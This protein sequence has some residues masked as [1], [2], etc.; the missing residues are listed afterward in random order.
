V[1]VTDLA[2][3]EVGK[4]DE[5]GVIWI[6]ADA[7]GWGW[8]VDGTPG[9]DDEFA[10]G[11]DGVLLAVSDPAAGR[12]DLLSVLAHEL[13]HAA[14]LGHQEHGL[15]TPTIV[16]GQRL[17][18]AV[19]GATTSAGATATAGATANVSSVTTANVSPLT[20]PDVSLVTTPEL[21]PAANPIV[22]DWSAAPAP[23][24]TPAAAN[25][26]WMADFANHLGRTQAEREPTAKLRIAAAPQAAAKLAGEAVRRISSLFG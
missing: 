9:T 4:T 8:F 19:T 20:A 3:L 14:G 11:A 23:V 25:P 6:D 15:M 10:M 22:I 24:A 12:M 1:R 18:P 26:G 21:P 17:A 13:A 16:A 2:W 7:G 5:E